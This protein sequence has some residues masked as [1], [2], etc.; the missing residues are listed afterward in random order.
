[1]YILRLFEAGLLPRNLHF[2]LWTLFSNWIEELFIG[3][4]AQYGELKR[5]A[6]VS[7]FAF[8]NGTGL[9]DLFKRKAGSWNRI[10]YHFEMTSNVQQVW[11]V[12]QLPYNKG[13]R[14]YMSNNDAFSLHAWLTPGNFSQLN[15]SNLLVWKKAINNMREFLKKW[16]AH[17]SNIPAQLRPWNDFVQNYSMSDVKRNLQKAWDAFGKGMVLSQNV[18]FE[19]YLMKLGNLTDAMTN[20]AGTSTHWTQKL[21]DDW[22][23]L[24]GSPN[25]TVYP[26]LPYNTYDVGSFKNSSSLAYR[27]IEIDELTES[28]C[29]AHMSIMRE[30]LQRMPMTSAR[31]FTHASTTKGTTLVIKQTTVPIGSSA[32]GGEPAIFLVIL[33]ALSFIAFYV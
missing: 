5:E 1:M 29:P 7:T 13:Y 3:L 32:I 18:F 15:A 28:S 14:V 4:A 24:F 2:V 26:G 33:A 16:S 9:V 12:D 25:P 21:Q 20:I 31:P 22:I 8:L 19:K 6:N 17:P 10:I 27:M 23:N 11:L 30:F